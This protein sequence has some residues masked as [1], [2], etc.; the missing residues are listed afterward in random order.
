MFCNYATMHG[1]LEIRPYYNSHYDCATAGFIKGLSSLREF[2][3]TYVNENHMI[4]NF[5]CSKLETI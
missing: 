1:T 2:G 4:F 3:E 5:S